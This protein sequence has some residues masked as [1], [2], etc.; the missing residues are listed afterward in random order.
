MTLT[1]LN[2]SS[3]DYTGYQFTTATELIDAIDTTLTSA[4]WTELA[5]TSGVS[6]FGQGTT[7][8][9][10]HSCYVEFVISG[11][12][13]T[14]RGW[15]ESAKT[16]GSPDAIHTLTFTSGS[17]NRLWITADE[18]SGCICIFNASG[19]CFGYHFGFLQRIDTTDQW[20]WMIGGLHSTGYLQAYSAKAKHAAT[21][22][23]QLSA[24][25]ANYSVFGTS[26]S[27]P[28]SAP[29]S[30]LDFMARLTV[31]TATN[32]TI[33][34]NHSVNTI[35]T[36]ICYLVHYGKLN[37][38]GNAICDPY[39]YFEGRNSTTAYGAA[40]STTLYFRGFVKH[41]YCGVASLVA[42]AQATNAI[43]PDGTSLGYRILSVGGTQWQ[44][45]RIL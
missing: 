20:A 21:N 5:K 24:D 41:A 13:L 12:T 6:W 16:T 36:N 33:G 44:G 32:S 17:T 37:Y 27:N 42:A 40:G 26:H 25:Y 1:F 38:D 2:G 10:S 34:G 14:I 35:N 30:T 43:A 45:M 3:P 31:D 39:C 7:V 23:K 28:A 19:A 15:H 8:V 4:G 9:G 22:W 18:D 29:L 11:S